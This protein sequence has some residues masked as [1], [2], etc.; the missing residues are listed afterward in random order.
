MEQINL[1]EN[2][3][4]RE[5]LIGHLEVLDKV[6]SLAF[7]TKD[8]VVTVDAIANYF[9][10][11]KEAINKL[12]LR[13]KEELESNGLKVIR[14]QELKE[15]K[16]SVGNGQDVQSLK[17][18]SALTLFT[19]R[20]VLN[21]A[22][23]LT[24]SKVAEKVRDYLLNLEDKVTVEQ[25]EEAIEEVTEKTIESLNL[26]LLRKQF[27]EEKKLVEIQSAVEKCI[28]FGM[29]QKEA[30]YLIQSAIVNKENIQVAILN[31]VKTDQDK[32]VEINRGIVREKIAY[33]A[34]H[35]FDD[36]YE[37]VYHTM[38]EKMRYKIGFNMR[39][40]RD[41]LKKKH[42]NSSSKVPSYL[43]LI[44][45][46]NAYDLADNAIKEIMDEKEE[47]KALKVEKQKETVAIKK[48]VKVKEIEVENKEED[49]TF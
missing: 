17:F 3:K 22:M 1:V 28:A 18:T 5:E 40:H 30:S 14:G 24:E 43:D 9:E 20:A 8:L 11:S 39:A 6:K 23:L 41:R 16:A 4:A 31:K 47:L 19:K 7:M 10:V 13:N 32:T 21:V 45:E 44:V 27:R 26:K 2:K 12:T 37:M 29:T 38:S 49:F 35:Y 42:G 48:A 46:F 34:K 33:V 36:D 25:K 15:F